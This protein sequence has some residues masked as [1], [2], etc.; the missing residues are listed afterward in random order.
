MVLTDKQLQSYANFSTALRQLGLAGFCSLQAKSGDI[1]SDRIILPCSDAFECLLRTRSDFSETALYRRS[2]HPGAYSSWRQNETCWAM[3][4][5]FLLRDGVRFV[6]VDC[7]RGRPGLDVV[8]TVVHACEVLWH[9]VTGRKTD[10]FAVQA[11][12]NGRGYNIPLIRKGNIC[13]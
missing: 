9:A 5:T 4:L 8:G 2:E 12:W 13:V 11:H 3:Q 7:D 6:D 1:R 10:P